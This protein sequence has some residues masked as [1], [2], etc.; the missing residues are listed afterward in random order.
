[1]E[2]GLRVVPYLYPHPPLRFGLIRVLALGVGHERGRIM[3]S[4]SFL[5]TIWSIWKERNFRC[6]EGGSTDVN[7]LVEKV[8]YLALWVSPNPLFKGISVNSIIHN[9]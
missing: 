4:V 2:V 3:W 5:A 6:F 8:K 1:M 7:I 9:W